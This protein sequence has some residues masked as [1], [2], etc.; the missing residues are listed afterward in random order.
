MYTPCIPNSLNNINPKSVFSCAEFY[1][2][3]A[4]PATGPQTLS[5]HTHVQVRLRGP[6]SVNSE[7]FKNLSLS[8]QESRVLATSGGMV[9]QV[10]S[11]VVC[12]LEFK[13]VR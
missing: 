12:D 9:G 3:A 7:S 4:R 6:L 11:F 5:R 1:Y 13:A 2:S 10:W 8:T